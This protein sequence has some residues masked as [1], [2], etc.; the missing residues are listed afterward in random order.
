MAIML[1]I[2]IIVYD[3]R[4]YGLAAEFKVTEETTYEDLEVLIA[5]TVDSNKG[6][7]FKLA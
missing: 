2:S 1:S 6:L 7:G 4:G 3:P 5:Y